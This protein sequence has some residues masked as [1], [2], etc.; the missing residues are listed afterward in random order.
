MNIRFIT[1]IL[2][3]SAVAFG[4]VGCSKSEPAPDSVTPTTGTK[5]SQT[6]APPQTTEQ[7]GAPSSQMGT[8]GSK[9]VRG[10]DTNPSN[11]K[12]KGR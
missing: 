1:G 11:L 2:L 8:A 4:L 5:S 9:E 3:V 6:S 7:S 10:A 12:K